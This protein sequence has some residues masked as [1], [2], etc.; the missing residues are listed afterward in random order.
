[1]KIRSGFVSNS[2]SSSFIVLSESK[3]DTWN[4]D[5][6]E[7]IHGTYEIGRKGNKTFGW[8]FETYHDINSKVNFAALQAMYLDETYSDKP[9]MKMLE[10]VLIKCIPG[11]RLVSNLL[12]FNY[13]PPTGK[14]WG[15][16]DHQSSAVEGMNTE[17]FDNPEVLTTF[18][19]SPSSYIETGNDNC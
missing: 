2:S 19:F 11:C 5:E 4:F 3:K 10:K 14:I 12:D 7:L 9:Y 18:I 15:Y 17:M 13:K 16:I 1:M 6:V 8:E